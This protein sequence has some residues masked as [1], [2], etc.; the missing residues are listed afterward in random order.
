M[1]SDAPSWVVAG[2]R[3]DVD[4]DRVRAA[5][6]SRRPDVLN[7][8][9]VELD[10]VRWP[11]KQLLEL[12][13]GMSRSTFITHAALRIF[14][15][16]GLSTSDWPGSERGSRTSTRPLTA[17]AGAEASA[18]KPDDLIDAVGVIVEFL[19]SQELTQRLAALEYDL[20][21]A[22]AETAQD[23]IGEDVSVD[24]L[25]AALLI[26]RTLGRISDVI[27]A[28]VICTVL[29]LILEPGERVVNRPSLAAGNDP[30]RLFDLETDRRVAEFKVSVWQ[31]ADAMRK[32]GAF[33]DLVHL[34]LAE[35]DRRR[36]LFVVGDQPAAFLN[37]TK[38]SCQW[39]LSRG[40][41]K[42][43][44]RFVDRYGEQ[45]GTISD[46]RRTHAGDVEIIDLNALIPGLREAI[47]GG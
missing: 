47:D 35:G 46:F 10:G 32:R 3:V 34:A 14:R 1:T 38:S 27:H 37:G 19:G 9:W 45:G 26:R 16:I 2:K 44:Q 25:A 13:T 18:T 42:L 4:V 40:S 39:G 33:A 15:S 31:G 21:G 6:L 29:P 41:D 7:R 20:V 24:T 43:R 30:S 5:A 28:A 23:V 8:H 22:T 12:A 36:Q 11:P 17:A